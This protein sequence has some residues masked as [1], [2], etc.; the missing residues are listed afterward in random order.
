MEF[1]SP[2]PVVDY[3]NA[4]DSDSYAPT[5]GEELNLTTKDIGMSVP[6]GIS[7]S[8]VSGI[9]SKIRMGAGSIEIGFPG[10]YSG[11]RQAQTPGMYGEDQ[12][13]A[14]RELA[15]INEIKLTTH[16][17]YPMMGIMGRDQRDNFSQTNARQNLHEIMRSIDFAADTAGSGS[18][19]VHTGEW[20]RPLTEI[21]VDDPTMQR[22][23]SYDPDSGRLLFKKI[24]QE[25][26]DAQFILLDDRT[27]QKMETVQRDRKI[28]VPR[29]KR[30]DKEYDG[31]YQDNL[32]IN[33]ETD[34]WMNKY[35]GQ[36]T[37]IKKGD[38][39]DYEGKK[40]I[41]PYN[42][43]Y[44][45]VPDFDPDSNRF[46]V[47]YKE[48]NDFVK[49]AKEQ[50]EFK[51]QHWKEM[52]GMNPEDDYWWY[53]KGVV[54]PDE[55][56]LHATLETNEG[57]SRGW[58][59][60]YA[61]KMD[62]HLK[63][64]SSLK[65]AREFYADL[66]EKMPKDE[67]WKLFKQ[68]TSITRFI[69]A[70]FAPPEYKNPV[71]II[72]NLIKETRVNL[73][74]ARQASA[75]QEQQAEDTAETKEHIITPYKR[76]KLHGARMY[77]EAGLRAMQRTKD[78]NNPVFLAIEN[79]FPDKF[80]GHPTELKYVIDESR[81]WFVRFLT[82]QEIPF[83]L[84]DKS[85]KDYKSTI[86]G[87][88][89]FYNSKMSKDEAEKMAER[90]IKATFDTGHANLWRKYWQPKPGQSIEQTDNDF[91]Q[92]YLKEFEKLAK[93][94]Y[95]GNIHLTD[96]FGFQ[97]DHLAPGQGNTPVKDVLKILKKHGYD[98]AITVE[99]G[100]DASTDVSDFHGLMKTWRYI[101][102]PIY[103]AYGGSSAG[104]VRPQ[105]WGGVQYSYF[106][107]DKPPYFIFGAYAPSN[108]WTLWSQVPME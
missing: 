84:M 54:Y 93:G 82:E 27:S 17:P 6:M 37:K 35:K 55:A 23:L 106:G 5:L 20:D 58:A 22:N 66:M 32:A 31:I 11:N 52:R 18:V 40:I 43:K 44:G 103:G 88:S 70:D 24:Q 108:D 97:D 64:L 38:Y 69:G 7:A 77:A 45:R 30:A 50:T 104:G 63:A 86:W 62:T 42:P 76:F 28:A 74:F 57:H 33:K 53:Y 92:W 39:I 51:R 14:I 8:N 78:P 105:T 101:G 59:L 89:E 47:D 98:K 80:G 21:N 25:A 73:E 10:A 94:G 71:E 72:D 29:W 100:A 85:N 79:I 36:T 26:H 68:D 61:E 1:Y 46:V 4:M 87:K 16:A 96:N 60:Q 9:Y 15:K 75:S 49:E 81:K 13:Q 99:P 90:Y 83:G 3:H 67:Q 56:Y 107:Q 95:I 102:S 19:V 34:K 41:D 2:G 65:G 91:K 12:R 48:F